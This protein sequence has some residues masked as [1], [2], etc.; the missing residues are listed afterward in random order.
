MEPLTQ[1]IQLLWRGEVPLWSA[2]WLWGQGV[3]ALVLA[4]YVAMYKLSFEMLA[5]FRVKLAEDAG[6]LAVA[7]RWLGMV[8]NVADILGIL[9]I[10]G[11]F[12]VVMWR[13]AP[14]TEWV[15]WTYAV[16]GYLLIFWLFVGLGAVWLWQ[17][18]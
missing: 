8:V 1:M 9:V 3:Y 12:T 2:F 13:A 14:N 10:T 4:A 16:R 15:G 5:P 7:V 11:F 17:N 18:R 6:W